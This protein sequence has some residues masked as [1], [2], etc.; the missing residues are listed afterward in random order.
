MANNNLPTKKKITDI[1]VMATTN[2]KHYATRNHFDGTAIDISRINGQK[3]ITTGVTDQIIKLQEANDS[4][5]YVPQFPNLWV[6]GR[7]INV[8]FE[9]AVRTTKFLQPEGNKLRGGH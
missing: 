4:F 1:Y 9:S 5:P 3:M 8:D 2:G 7:K 6:L